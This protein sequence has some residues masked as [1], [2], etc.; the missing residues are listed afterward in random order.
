L[1]INLFPCRALE[2][3]HPQGGLAVHLYEIF[4][5]ATQIVVIMWVLTPDADIKPLTHHA[6]RQAIASGHYPV[7]R[8]EVAMR[9]MLGAIIALTVVV[10][11]TA[12]LMASCSRAGESNAGRHPLP[13]ESVMKLASQ[14]TPSPGT[15][16]PI[17]AAAPPTFDT[18]T[19]G[20]G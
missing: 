6:F 15:I 13:E 3:V 17:D 16:P 4:T 12:M 20:L 19:F 5:D 18:A 11:S 1:I 7:H 9:K 8:K 14:K 2:N 10:A